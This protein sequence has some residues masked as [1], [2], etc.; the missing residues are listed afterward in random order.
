MLAGISGLLV[1]ACATTQ[2]TPGDAGAIDAAEL[3]DAPRPDAASAVDADPPVPD[4][5]PDAGTSPYRHTILID[6]TNDF[7]A[8]DTF[9]TTSDPEYVAHASWDDAN[10]YLGYR[11]P[12]LDPAAVDASTKWLFVYLDADPGAA[13]GAAASMTYNT[14]HAA[15]PAGFGAELYYRWKCDGSFATLEVLEGTTWVTSPTAITVARSG[16]F[17]ELALPRSL[18]AGAGVVGITAWM[19]NEKPGLESSYAGLYQD[20]FTDGYAADLGLT[21]YLAADFSSA[22]NPSDPSHAAP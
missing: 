10:V 1:A 12:D 7:A 13:T 16:D 2:A 4:A 5:A 9:A 3:T 11:G 14:Q 15:F 21:R 19:I 22:A 17:L 6:G 8:G 20:N 18:F